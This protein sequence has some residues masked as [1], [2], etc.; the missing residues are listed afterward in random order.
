MQL[1]QEIRSCGCYLQ[2]RNRELEFQVGITVVGCWRRKQWFLALATHWDQLLHF[3][4]TFNFVLGY[5][6]L[7]PPWWL[8]G[9][10]STCN[11]GVAGNVGLIPGWERSPEGRH[12]NPLQFSCLENS[13]D[14]G[15]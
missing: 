2:M 1:K 4:L 15:A 6:R 7:G 5:S 14:R 10:E 8:S 3:F 11:A 12:G 13:M 9:K